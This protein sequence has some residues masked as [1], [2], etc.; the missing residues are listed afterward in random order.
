MGEWKGVKRRGR[1]KRGKVP[2][3]SFVCGVKKSMMNDRRTDHIIMR[4]KKLR[5]IQG[6]ISSFA[7]I[8]ESPPGLACGC[9]AAVGLCAV[10]D[11]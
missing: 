2:L 10:T 9:E 6:S 3:L 1:G 4:G 8:A 5:H 11:R 7:G